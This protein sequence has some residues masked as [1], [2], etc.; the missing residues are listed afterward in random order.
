MLCQSV[1]RLLVFIG[2]N[3]SKMANWRYQSPKKR[4]GGAKI[5]KPTTTPRSLPTRLFRRSLKR[6]VPKRGLPS[7]QPPLL[8]L[9][10]KTRATLPTSPLLLRKIKRRGPSRSP[11]NYS[12]RNKK[13]RLNQSLVTLIAVKPGLSKRNIF[14][15][16]PVKFCSTL[17]NGLQA[18]TL[19]VRRSSAISKQKV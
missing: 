10:T 19:T 17:Q 4:N 16:L 18:R 3:I 7:P 6:V 14:A 9:M 11:R 8:S 15:K 13:Y 5:L 2:R 12:R 1:F